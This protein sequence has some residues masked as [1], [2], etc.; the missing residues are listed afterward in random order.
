MIEAPDEERGRRYKAVDPVDPPFHYAAAIASEKLRMDGHVSIRISNDV[1]SHRAA[2]TISPF[3]VRFTYDPGC[4]FR[5]RTV[6]T[7]WWECSR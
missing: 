3:K 4:N 5:V 2:G 6:I 1:M 7:L